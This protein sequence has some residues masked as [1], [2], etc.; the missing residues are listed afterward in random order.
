M[1]I[2]LRKKWKTIKPPP[3]ATINY[4]NK[5]TNGL[6]F[7]SLM[8]S[9]SGN[10]DLVRDSRAI[11][12]DV[13][14][15]P[16]LDSRSNKFNATTSYL[17]FGY[18]LGK[19]PNPAP[20]TLVFKITKLGIGQNTYGY[21]YG[22]TP[23][24]SASG[25]RFFTDEAWPGALSIG[26]T[27]SSAQLPI[28]TTV[29]TY[30]NNNETKILSMTADGGILA[31]GIH[32]YNIA[33][34]NVVEADYNLAT[35]GSGSLVAENNNPLYI[36]NRFGGSRTFNGIIHFGYIWNRVLSAKE[37]SDIGENPYGFFISNR[38]RTY[39]ISGEQP[40]VESRTT[41]K[42]SLPSNSKITIPSSSRL[43]F[44]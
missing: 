17:N 7:C 9:Y 20:I 3:G 38:R 40:P 43:V 36:G 13:I 5:I 11:T 16:G 37:L 19:F 1:S 6:V 26:F 23:T 8:N 29:G 31:S 12:N 32:I 44:T 18:D 34:G 21:I 2:I 35:D 30:L 22:K 33:N 10:I 41:K 24:G 15:L 42:L 4:G 28:K 25:S 27:S 39:Y 14:I